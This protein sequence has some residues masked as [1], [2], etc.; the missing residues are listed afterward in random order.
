MSPEPNGDP[1]P[2]PDLTSVT[3]PGGPGGTPVV[4]SGMAFGDGPDSAVYFRLPDRGAA[5][6]AAPIRTWSDGRIEANV[7]SLSAFGSGGPLE[8]SVVTPGGESAALPFT[9]HEDG[10]P[11]LDGV[12]PAAALETAPV[13]LTGRG[14][15]RGPLADPAVVFATPG[16]AGVAAPVDS[17]TPTTIV[18]K[19]P[20][21]AALGPA[22]LKEVSVRTPWGSSA[23][24][25]FELAEPP[26]IRTIVPPSQLPGAVISIHGRAFGAQPPGVLAI[27]DLFRAAVPMRVTT[28]SDDLIE[29]IVPSFAELRTTGPKQVVVTSVWGDGK[30]DVTVTSD[31][32][33]ITAWTRLEVH[34]RDDDLEA[35][36]QRGLRAEVYDALWL[37]GRQW[38]MRELDGEDAGSP[39]AVRV[40]GETARLAR[41]RPLGRQALAADVPAR[42]VPLE[43]L[44]EHEQVLPGRD[45]STRFDDRRLAV[46]SGLQWLRLLAR[47]LSKP[48]DIDKYRKRYAEWVGMAPPT[49]AERAT[50]DSGTI[51][52]LDTVAGRVPDG[53]QLYVDLQQAL[54]ERGSQIPRKP[55]IEGND[56]AGFLQAVVEWFAWWEGLFSQPTTGGQTWDPSRMEYGFEA[57]AETV[58]GEVVLA[59][60]EY[61]GRRLDW[62]SL[63][64]S[65]A[66]SLRA[67]STV[68]SAPEPQP[69]ER[70]LV[71]V[72]VTFPG[73][74]APRF[75]AMENAA[76]NF[77]G[78]SAGPTDLMRL[79]FVEFATTYGN[80]W[81]S[82]P[83]DRLPVGGICRIASLTVTDT[84]GRQTQVDPLADRIG[85]FRL[86][87][88]GFRPDLVFIA[89][90]LPSTFE[91]SPLEEVMLVRDEFANLAW[92]VERVVTGPG[93]LPTNRV[94]SWR[95][96]QRRAEA[97]APSPQLPENAP[98]LAYHL[99]TT[100]PDYWIPFHL[101][102]EKDSKGVVTARWLTRAALP[103]PA[104]D[105][106][107]LPAGELLERASPSLQLFDEV[108]SREGVRL[109]RHW[110]YG[111]APDGSTH[112]WRTRRRDMG[113]GEGSSGLRF[114]VVERRRK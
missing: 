3:P 12:A 59:G 88:L 54:P 101:T 13:T 75:W 21:L 106:L 55:P 111:R 22:G 43:A 57:S 33:S 52:F 64:I 38:Q 23:T 85:G 89:D 5:N 49:D 37:L 44:V 30:A 42:P 82:F 105:M 79:L 114:D 71:P 74:A 107:I 58:G 7:P 102:V 8:V 93:G 17:W 35:G 4:L 39:V 53:A 9:L 83:V 94:E 19:V 48:D 50:L 98:E 20:A 56:R 66:G 97:A 81:F 72:P 62:Y 61:G 14:F 70:V 84:F 32:S 76:V 18:V 15:G 34:A 51:R 40:T 11:T 46:E 2:P 110:Q 6:V 27:G 73:M 31:R 78:V 77:G 1:P 45:G 91:S 29:A 10:P 24:L 96:R 80:D 92:G 87:D 112:L 63:A 41:W 108:L 90:A 16:T 26:F 68:P 100:I 28:W 95:D 99:A 36:L 25:S 67:D 103:D 60:P 113:Q 47:N 69:F 109:R 86:F 104:T 65:P